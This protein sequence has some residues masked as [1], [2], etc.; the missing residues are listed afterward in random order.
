M[1]TSG[2][3]N[4]SACDK[5]EP[6]ES[7]DRPK[8]IYFGVFFDGT[9][10]NMVQK[11]TAERYRQR[12]QSGKDDKDWDL[13]LNH[14]LNEFGANDLPV[15]EVDK[16]TA[17]LLS[18]DE[19]QDTATRGSG[20]SNIAILHSVYQGMSEEQYK[21]EQNSCDIF[22]YNIYVEGAGTDA[23]NDGSH[24]LG[25]G[26]GNGVTGVVALVSKAVVMVSN[27]LEGFLDSRPELHFDVFGFSRGATCARL[28]AYL[29]VRGN[30]KLGCEKNFEKFQASSLYSGGRLHFLEEDNLSDKRV[31]FL[32]I[33]DTV[34]SIGITYD[35]NVQDYGLFSPTLKKVE[36]TFHLCA[37]DEFREHFALTDIGTAADA[38]NAELFIPGC[39]SDVGGTYTLSKDKFSLIFMPTILQRTRLYVDK[40][41]SSNGKTEKVDAD[42]LQ[43]L[44]W[45]NSKEE[46]FTNIANGYIDCHRKKVFGGYSNIPL[47]MMAKRVKCKTSLDKF[48]T[49]P[50]DRFDIP[51]KL[52]Q[53]GET[54]LSLADSITGR[55]WFYPGGSYSSPQ[56]K[57]LR[58]SYLHFSASDALLSKKTSVVNA[59]SKKGNVICRI[60]YRGNSGNSSSKYMC[61]YE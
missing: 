59:P 60:V 22:R 13:K 8:K 14:G 43:L 45:V 33:Y 28:F 12:Q 23:E 47:R 48:S 52:T 25:S 36:N 50:D 39:H 57:E 2:I 37:L 49:F 51:K 3:V 26:F 7:Q 46:T 9:G 38:N 32:G 6:K 31:D 42:S 21:Q 34:S 16:K 5:Q 61:D 40:P 17:E 35:D 41:H 18:E 55:D 24:L 44:G 4:A 1:A 53:L 11:D 10:N 20:Y 54:M 29:V 58:Q 56:Y 19:W 27:I 30:E 15:K